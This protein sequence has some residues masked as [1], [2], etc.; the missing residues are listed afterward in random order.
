MAWETALPEVLL[1][2]RKWC[3]ETLQGE[4]QVVQHQ[5]W[6]NWDPPTVIPSQGLVLS[7][8]LSHLGRGNLPHLW[9]MRRHIQD[10]QN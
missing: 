10:I 8:L 9:G 7:T 2:A 1:L 4:N 3:T 5:G 6:K